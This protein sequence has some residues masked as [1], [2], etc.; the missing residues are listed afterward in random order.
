MKKS[1]LKTVLAFSLTLAASAVSYGEQVPSEL[2]D[3]RAAESKDVVKDQA[4]AAGVSTFLKPVDAIA[5]DVADVD[6]ERGKI[7]QKASDEYYAIKQAK[8]DR[9]KSI[10]LK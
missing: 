3:S 4:R 5:Q 10:L 2:F 7:A 9:L 1:N 6:P 8:R